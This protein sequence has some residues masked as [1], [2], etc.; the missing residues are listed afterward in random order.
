[1]SNSLPPLIFD[2]ITSTIGNTPIVRINSISTLA[3]S[4]ELSNVELLVKLEYLNSLSGSIKDRVAKR[5][6]EGIFLFNNI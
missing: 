2:D 1:M 4:F 6:L 3:S 5:I